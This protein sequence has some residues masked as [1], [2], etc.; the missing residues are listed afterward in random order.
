MIVYFSFLFFSLHFF[1][2][3]TFPSLHFSTFF[4]MFSLWSDCIFSLSFSFPLYPYIFT[5]QFLHSSHFSIFTFFPL[6]FSFP[7]FTPAPLASSSLLLLLSFSS[8]PLRRGG[9]QNGVFSKTCR[10]QVS[11]FF[12]PFCYLFQAS[13]S[14]CLS[15]LGRVFRGGVGGDG[16]GL[17]WVGLFFL[18]FPKIFFLFFVLRFKLRVRDTVL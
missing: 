16:V 4:F 3:F 1:F 9:F 12:F 17:G 14:G 8:P 15:V 18:F 2:I 13:V 11:I 6:F 10:D 5:F 7:L